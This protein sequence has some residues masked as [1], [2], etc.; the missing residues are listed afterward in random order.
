MKGCQNELPM[1]GAIASH[2]CSHA[3]SYFPVKRGNVCEHGNNLCTIA[4]SCHRF[5]FFHNPL[6]E[7]NLI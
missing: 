4:I 1:S 6:C 7:M 5:L 2:F 3:T